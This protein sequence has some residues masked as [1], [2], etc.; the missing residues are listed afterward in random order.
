MN[1]SIKKLT[2]GVIAAMCVAAIIAGGWYLSYQSKSS[3]VE[4]PILASTSSTTQNNIQSN[5]SN[6][7]QEKQN[8][9]QDTSTNSNLTQSNDNQEGVG[10]I[11]KEDEK[12]EEA[13]ENEKL[14][15]DE[16]AKK[17]KEDEEAEKL[18]REQ[19]E[20]TLS[21]QALNPDQY[22]ALS[23]NYIIFEKMVRKQPR[24]QY[25][26]ENL[27][28][29][30]A[31]GPYTIKYV[32]IGTSDILIT[33]PV[34]TKDKNNAAIPNILLLDFYKFLY[35]THAID[36]LGN[37]ITIDCGVPEGAAGE[38]SH[39]AF[40]MLLYKIQNC[41][42]IFIKNIG[43]IMQHDVEHTN[44][45]N[46]EIMKTIY[47]DITPVLMFKDVVLNLDHNTL[48]VL[49]E[50]FIKK[51]SEEHVRNIDDLKPKLTQITI[52]IP[53]VSNKTSEEKAQIDRYKVVLMNMDGLPDWNVQLKKAKS[54]PAID[55]K[56]P[57]EYE[58]YDKV[59]FISKP[60]RIITGKTK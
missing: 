36:G 39:T 2:I 58:Q 56:S 48:N 5:E 59:I 32:G 52:L 18:K 12:L 53:P 3:K 15:E 41:R 42:E 55:G 38:T 34:I 4:T 27:I 29:F 19:E 9:L 24:S 6:S 50:F 33:V 14:K 11:T 20:K 54:T 28:D 44:K 40:K 16:K 1:K 57:E 30:A 31:E 45:K 49:R 10:N 22:I 51:Q 7:E 21:I 23:K 47:M 60:S 17:P 25:L 46:I 8:Q 37:K 13:K 26:T 35:N 43:N